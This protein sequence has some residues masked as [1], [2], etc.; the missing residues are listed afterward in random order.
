MRLT[1]Q[2]DEVGHLNRVIELQG[3]EIRALKDE[4]SRLKRLVAVLAPYQV[5]DRA[6]ETPP[7]Y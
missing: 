5:S 6:D 1:F 2:E 4:V 3:V 7:H